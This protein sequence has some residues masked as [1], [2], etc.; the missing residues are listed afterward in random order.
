MM[1]VMLAIEFGVRRD[2]GVFD[3]DA[4]SAGKTKRPRYGIAAALAL[5]AN[6]SMP[7]T[8]MLPF[9]D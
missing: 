5:K 3:A 8:F 6:G 4:R 7:D 1:S 9:M 2:L